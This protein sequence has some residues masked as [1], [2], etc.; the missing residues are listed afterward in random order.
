VW[1][2]QSIETPREATGTLKQRFKHE[3]RKTISH[4]GKTKIKKQEDL[5]TFSLPSGTAVWFQIIF[6]N[7]LHFFDLGV[8]N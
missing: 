5:E 7:L 4:F 2:L 1:N 6:H 3:C 8:P